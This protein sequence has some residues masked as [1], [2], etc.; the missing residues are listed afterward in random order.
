MIDW[1]KLKPYKNDSRKSFEMLCYVIAKKQFE[2]LGE[3]TPIDDTGGGDGVEFYLK[4]K[5][6]DEWGWQ[7]KFFNDT[8]RLKNGGRKRQIEKSLE[9][10]ILV[11]KKLRKWILCTNTDFTIEENNFFKV[12]LYRKQ[13]KRKQIKLEHW[14]ESNFNE[15]LYKPEFSGVN[16]YFFGKLELNL[17]WFK[18]TF[19]KQI[20]IVKNKYEEKLHVDTYVE[21]NLNNLLLGEV[22]K[23]NA[24][25]QYSTLRSGLYEFLSKINKEN[26]LFIYNLDG[27]SDFFNTQRSL[28]VDILNKCIKQLDFFINKLPSYNINNILCISKIHNFQSLTG[29]SSLIHNFFKIRIDKINVIEN[30]IEKEISLYRYYDNNKDKKN[31]D[32]KLFNASEFIHFLGFYGDT[33]LSRINDAIKKNNKTNSRNLNILSDAGNGKTHLSC[34]FIESVIKKNKPAIYIS[35]QKFSYPSNLYRQLFDILE[36]PDIYSLDVFLETLQ[37]V[38]I[39]Y[40][41]ILPILIDGLNEST[42]N[43]QLSPIW[44]NDLESFLNNLKKYNRILFITTC[45]STYKI[46]IWGE[47][48]TFDFV[49]LYGFNDQELDV[50]LTK[51]FKEY[52]IINKQISSSINKYF[53][54]PLYLKIFCETKN[55]D[56]TKEVLVHIGEESIYELFDEYLQI[57]SKELANKYDRIVPRYSNYNILLIIAEY[58]WK[59]NTRSIPLKDLKMLLLKHNE[60]EIKLSAYLDENI[61]IFQDWVKD[62][63]HIIFTYDMLSGYLIS[64]FL[65]PNTLSAFIVL[66][67]S[68]EFKDKLFNKSNSQIHPLYNDILKCI[69]ALTPQNYNKFLHEIINNKISLNYSIRAIF[70]ISPHLIN[71]R[72]KKV[73]KK[74][75]E[76]DLNRIKLFDLSCSTFTQNNHPLNMIYWS[77]ILNNMKMNERDVSW[78]EFIRNSYEIDFQ[79]II[80]ELQIHS[81]IRTSSLNAID[82]QYIHLL[83][84]LNMWVLTSTCK[85]YRD[86]AT[87]SLYY[88]GR[89]YFNEFYEL[90]NFSLKIDD[91]YVSERMAAALYGI[92]LAENVSQSN[93]LDKLLPGVAKDIY[94]LFFNSKAKYYTYHFLKRDYLLKIIELAIYR[95]PKLGKVINVNKVR[96]AKLIPPFKW[97]RSKDKNSAQY[98]NGNAP[99]GMDFE[100]YTIGSLIPNRH[101]YDNKNK[102]FIKAVENIYWRIYNLGYSFEK[103][104]DIDQD[105]ASLR[106]NYSRH[107]EDDNGKIDRYG[108]KY[109]WIA[110]Y[111]LFGYKHDLGQLKEHYEDE[112]RTFIADLD[113]SFPVKLKE[114]SVFKKDF[115]GNRKTNLKRW[116]QKGSTPNLKPFLEINN[117]QNFG[118]KWLLLDGY[119]NQTDKTNNRYLFCFVRSFLVK[120]S[121]NQPFKKLLFKQDL[122]GRWLPEKH[123][124]RESYFNEIPWCNNF[125]ANSKSEFT[126]NTGYKSNTEIKTNL[127]FYENNRLINFNQSIKLSRIVKKYEKMLD[128][129]DENTVDKMFL[130][131]LFKNNIQLKIKNKK[132]I[133]KIQIKKTFLI[134]T[135]VVDLSIGFNARLYNGGGITVPSKQLCLQ[136]NLET[137]PQSFNMFDNQGKLAAIYGKVPNELLENGEHYLYIRKDLL[138]DYL[139]KNELKLIWAY[140]GER[141]ARFDDMSRLEIVAKENYSHKVFYKVIEYN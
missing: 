46:P 95:H 17:E 14:G 16:N 26:E 96:K 34:H 73:V 3:F 134:D 130:K 63:E 104:K 85:L 42:I 10:S 62:G 27:S 53:K 54:T 124:N 108:K 50:A 141:E 37:T 140:W 135:P 66:S 48:S 8:G 25:D 12:E 11:H 76:N 45:R 137:H 81:C 57:V 32:D 82:I 22:F 36:I 64:K 131:E 80:D 60:S 127:E 43:G 77:N 90:F 70:E 123:E 120:K 97:K 72:A 51:Y 74:L 29:L 52:K 88:Y 105:I 2:H 112:P 15:Y 103:F 28:F 110:Y 41:C 19:N 83:A 109:S 33:W 106:V 114:Y 38:A 35:G 21:N 133:S 68:S 107:N 101:N 55:R 136:L 128:S 67:N 86:T 91:P 122:G 102:E 125:K 20:L 87:K 98:R 138:E 56:K 61:I 47:N 79:K 100:N 4:L 129:K 7:A 49:N 93:F 13:I 40:D 84:L 59:E 117:L 39:V 111:E 44:K 75:F 9:K 30:G 126:F 58:L 92:C 121:D 69:A 1:T 6:G 115:L 65:L 31:Y 118:A 5:N 78:S 139:E 116:V 113:P 119:L 99:I 23:K 132:V 71:D 24:I 18:N 89:N 94:H